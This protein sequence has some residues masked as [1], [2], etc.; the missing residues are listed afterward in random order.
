LKIN[1]FRGCRVNIPQGNPFG[2]IG[3]GPGE[4]IATLKRKTAVIS[5]GTTVKI[6]SIGH[7]L[8]LD[9]RYGI[10]IAD[11]QRDNNNVTPLELY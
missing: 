5:Y 6:K 10:D 11:L 1:K 9:I 8:K 4:T 7:Y 2:T 3:K